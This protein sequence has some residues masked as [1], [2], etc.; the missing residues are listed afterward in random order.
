MNTKQTLLLVIT[1]LAGT[2]LASAD[3][4]AGNGL[5][6]RSA[7][8]GAYYAKCIPS[9]R[10]GTNGQTQIFIATRTNDMLQTTFDWYSSNLYLQGTAWGISVV[11]FGPWQRG[12]SAS[13]NDLAIAFYM[14][15]K[16]LKSYST[17][18]IAGSTT[19]VSQSISHYRVFSKIPG[20]RW[21]KSND[22]AFDVTRSDGRQLSFDV[23]TGE[24]IQ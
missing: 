8:Y 15:K 21:I 9:E 14:N 22:Y 17:L 19:N 10:Y 23:R 13:T 11:R 3:Q 4:E 24:I 1:M 2:F 20:Y 7:Q 16:L 6:V 5:Y 18:D 12:S